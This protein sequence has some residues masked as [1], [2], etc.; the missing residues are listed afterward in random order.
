MV[1]NDIIGEK[2]DKKPTSFKSQLVPEEINP[3]RDLL[4]EDDS[5]AL[6]IKN[7]KPEEFPLT[8]TGFN[9]RPSS[10]AQAFTPHRSSVK[11]RILSH[12]TWQ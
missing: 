10:T 8:R 11:R 12:D 1:K 6:V 3:A 4:C 7:C 2:S 9:F 5:E